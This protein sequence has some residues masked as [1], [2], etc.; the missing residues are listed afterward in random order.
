MINV[1]G[2]NTKVD[3]SVSSSWRLLQ[4]VPANDGVMHLVSPKVKAAMESAGS[5]EFSIQ[6][7]D[8]YYD[9]FHIFL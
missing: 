7:G 6:P 3:G 4:T 8:S 9:A 2:C 1:Y 5:F